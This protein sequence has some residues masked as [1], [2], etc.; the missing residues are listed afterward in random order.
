LLDDASEAVGDAFGG[1]AVEAEGE[2]VEV[3]RQML[4]GDRAVVGAEQSALGR[5]N[6]KWIAGGRSTASPQLAP[7][8]SGS[9]A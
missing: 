4:L 9:W 1:S 5:P 6:T 7:S 8:L 3:G 2:L